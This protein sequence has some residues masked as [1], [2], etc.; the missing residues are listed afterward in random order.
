MQSVISYRS[1][2]DPASVLADCLPELQEGAY[3]NVAYVRHSRQF[4]ENSW[5]LA[6]E[7]LVDLL[8]EP[9]GIVAVDVPRDVAAE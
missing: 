7:H 1:K 8:R 3:P 4:K 9:H 5:R 6:R 2:S